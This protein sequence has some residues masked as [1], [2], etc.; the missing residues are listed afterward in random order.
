[1]LVSAVT[2]SPINLPKSTSFRLIATDPEQCRTIPPL[3]DTPF[4]LLAD[5]QLRDK[6]SD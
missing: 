4:H 5:G 3:A 6:G 1:M 2:K